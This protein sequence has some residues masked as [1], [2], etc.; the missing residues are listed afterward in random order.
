MPDFI[1]SIGKLRRATDETILSAAKSA[2][3]EMRRNG[4]VAVGDISNNACTLPVKRDS[5]MLY[6]TFVEVFGLDY[7]RAEEIFTAAKQVEKEYH[8]AEMPVSILPH[9]LY[10]VSQALWEML[11]QSYASSPPQV[12]SIHHHECKD[13]LDVFW[14]GKGE[15]ADTLRKKG[16]LTDRK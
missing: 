9:A 11:Q 5:Q 8:G 3:S 12:I 6:R 4:I 1:S 7:S 13:E 16:L 14:E 2:D 10:S 15:L